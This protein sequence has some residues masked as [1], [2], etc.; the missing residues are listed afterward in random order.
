M[1]I[2]HSVLKYFL[3]F[4]LADDFEA[5]SVREVI[6]NIVMVYSGLLNPVTVI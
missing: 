5:E 1:L 3:K 2:W 6:Y 4:E